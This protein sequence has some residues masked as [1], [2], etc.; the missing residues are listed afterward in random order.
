[1]MVTADRRNSSS[2]ENFL[3]APRLDHRDG[4]EIGRQRVGR[5]SFG[6]QL[7]EAMEGKIHGGEFAAGAVDQGGG[8]D[9]D[10]AVLLDDIDGL[11]EAAA[12]GDDVFNHGETLAGLDGE[13]AAE[14]EGAGVI[15]F[16]E[17]VGFAELAGDFLTDEDAT[18][19]GGN[20]G[21]KLGAA[22][23]V[24][25][26]AADAFGHLGVAQKEGALEELAA[27]QAGAEDEVAVEEGAG[28]A[29]E[30]KN[31]VLGHGSI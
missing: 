15:F 31:V 18:E 19:G 6:I 1:M 27:V 25:E 10:S 13:T 23:L 2:G 28:L 11:H 4:R 7:D 24:G 29:E 30:G 3:F 9:H 14:N 21:V 20:D 16:G 17:N 5:E 8:G 26:G 22:E 12:A